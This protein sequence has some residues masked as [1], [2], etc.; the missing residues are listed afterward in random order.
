MARLPDC[1]I[2]RRVF[3]D[4]DRPRVSGPHSVITRNGHDW[5]ARDPLVVAAVEALWAR[6]CI[7]DGDTP[8]ISPP[9][10]D[11]V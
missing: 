9:I 10:P 1:W 7:I 6:S 11:F 5:T 8:S 4:L 2:H 3:A